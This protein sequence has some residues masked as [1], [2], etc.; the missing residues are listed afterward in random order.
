MPTSVTDLLRSFDKQNFFDGTNYDQWVQEFDMTFGEDDNLTAHVKGTKSPPNDT[1]ARAAWVK[2]DASAR[3]ALYKTI[4]SNAIRTTHFKTI[5]PPGSPQT[6]NKVWLSLK[7]EYQKDSRASRFE[8]KK[9][10]YNPSH[11]VS[12]PVSI[13][14]QDIV[15]AANSLTALGHTPASSDVVDSVLMNLDSS[16][17]V[18]RTLLTSQPT[19][20]TLDVVKKMLVDQ[21]DE[22][23]VISGQPLVENQALFAKKGATKDTAKEKKARKGKKESSGSSSDSDN[24][25]KLKYDWLNP[26][27]N[28]VCHRCG[29]PGHR[30]SRCVADMPQRIKDKIF[31]EIKQRRKA[32]KKNRERPPSPAQSHKAGLSRHKYA[33]SDSEDSSDSDTSDDYSDQAHFTNLP[34]M[35][36]I[37]G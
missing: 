25:S 34:I 16:F 15:A 5:D 6:A 37:Q 26:R 24:N 20:P 33:A 32:G 14:I 23:S 3:R 18:I 10:L 7:S 35:R 31:E 11:D 13:Y 4:S 8:L 1:T 9:R 30:S 36:R 28:D 27:N 22:R 12:K 19:E 2:T 29:L 17:A 21:E